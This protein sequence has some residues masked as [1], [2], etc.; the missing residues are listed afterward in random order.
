MTS[1]FLV[2]RNVVKDLFITTPQTHLRHLYDACRE[3]VSQSV[4]VSMETGKHHF[5]LN[6]AWLILLPS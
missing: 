1:I 3:H 6:K 2:G 5:M 4:N